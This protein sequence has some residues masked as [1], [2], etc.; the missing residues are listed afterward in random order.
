M[1]IEERSEKEIIAAIIGANQSKLSGQLSV[2]PSKNS[3]SYANKPSNLFRLK[4]WPCLVLG[5]GHGTT[6][7]SSVTQLNLNRLNTE[8]VRYLHL[9][10]ASIR[11]CA[12]HY[13]P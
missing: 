4:W 9:F 3:D 2:T 12:C 6:V 10:I 5:G 7:P 11:C 8:I 13:T 1:D